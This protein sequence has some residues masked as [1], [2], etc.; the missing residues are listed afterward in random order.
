[1]SDNESAEVSQLRLEVQ[2]LND[3]LARERRAKAYRTRRVLSGI[4]VVLA[5]LA[6]VLALLSVWAVRTLTDTEMF[7]DRVG[8]VIEQ[9]EVA[10]AI[11]DAA[12][13][14]LVDAL[15]LENR[16]REVLPEEVALAAAPITNAAENYLAD[17][18]TKLVQTEQFQAAWDAALTTGHEL[19][20]AVLSGSDTEAIQNEN[21]VIVLDL[22]PIVNLMLAESADFI[23]DLVGRQITAPTLTP[24][25]IDQAVTFLEDQL[26]TDLPPDFGQ[27]TLVASE[28]LAT[29]Q[30]AYQAVRALIWLAPLVAAVLIGLAI[31][32]SVRRI[33][34]AATIVVGTGLVL[35]VLGMALNPLQSSIV[36]AVPS[37]GLSGAVNA[38]FNTILDSLRSGI[39]LVTVLAVI[40]AA[41]LFFSGDSG[42][43]TTGRQQ[44]RRA[45][46]LAGKYPGWFLSGGAL[47]A[48]LVLAALPGRS[49][50]Q[51]LIVLLM[52]A[53]YALAVLLASRF[54]PGAGDGS[55]TDSATPVG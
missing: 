8:S 31:A 43:A 1:M 47:A 4:L 27:I 28:N 40:A 30:S 37:E 35:L 44:V 51:F 3:Q 11:G 5:V 10:S 41:V 25:T 32:V 46:S 34:T 45:P 53:A 20:I 18:A 14:Q 48:L 26:G 12:A 15:D 54:G 49:W 50:T 22:T 33:R 42:I 38:G 36:D 24:E 21:G 7:V 6:S 55:T 17:G 9:P 29:A 16:L 19:T 52:Y 39:V 13:G 23:S 2:A